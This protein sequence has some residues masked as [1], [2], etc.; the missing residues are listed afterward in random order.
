M[1]QEKKLKTEKKA[2][3][4]DPAKGIYYVGHEIDD[5][6]L[7][8]DSSEPG[9]ALVNVVTEQTYYKRLGKLSENSITYFPNEDIVFAELELM[10]TNDYGVDLG[11]AFK[12]SFAGINVPK[13]KYTHLISV[14]NLFN[15]IE[16]YHYSSYTIGEGEILTHIVVIRIK[17]VE[18]LALCERN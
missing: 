18:L 14:K 17:R 3:E 10:S 1:V 6:E 8:L 15:L 4:I 16:N 7:L 9:D 11:P 2:Q 12:D 13:E 5:T